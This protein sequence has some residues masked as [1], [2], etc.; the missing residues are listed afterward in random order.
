MKQKIK[1][2]FVTAFT[3]ILLLS[4]NACSLGEKRKTF[5]NGGITITLNE[6]FQQ[7]EVEGSAIYLESKII[8]VVGQKTLP[9]EIISINETVRT[10][11]RFVIEA[12][13]IPESTIIN[14]KLDPNL[15]VIYCYLTYQK[16]VG[17][18]LLSYCLTTFKSLSAFYIIQFTC[19]TNIYQKQFPKFLKWANTITVS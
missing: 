9:N 2:L 11:T 18:T 10:F 19:D 15:E 7:K 8:I 4:I 17:E 16:Q 5:T 6:D 12:N 14:E 3:I 1:N 13:N